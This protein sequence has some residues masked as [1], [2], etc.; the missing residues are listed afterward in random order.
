MKKII[1]AFFA[2]LTATPIIAQKTFNDANAEKRSLGD[3]NGIEVGT[4]IEL[5]LS[6]GSSNEVAVSAS[7]T[8]S[9]DR[10]VTK[11]D[12]GILKIHYDSKIGAVNRRN[13]NKKLRAYVSYKTLEHLKANT[14]AEVKLNNVLKSNKLDIEANTGALIDG[15]INVGSLTVNQHTGSKITLA[16]TAGT[17]KL[18][19]HTG[20]KFKGEQMITVDC[21]VSVHSGAQVYIHANKSLEGKANS[22]GLIR[23]KGNAT[24][25][26]IK[27]GSG[28]SVNKI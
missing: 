1:I 12:N 28:G 8:E 4:G 18:E 27:T 16:G 11:V 20:S 14:G 13:E 19:G 2:L 23:Y 24:R 6:E 21:S 17:V 22:G 26:D 9:R 3:F 5:W 7:D 10:I 15:E 25:I